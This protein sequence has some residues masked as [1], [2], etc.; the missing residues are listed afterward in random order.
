[1]AAQIEHQGA[2]VG[3]FLRPESVIEGGSYEPDAEERA[4][5]TQVL[6][7]VVESWPT[8]SLGVDETTAVDIPS[9]ASVSI[10]T[11]PWKPVQEEEVIHGRFV[12]QS[13]RAV[14]DV[15]PAPAPARRTTPT[16][17]DTPA[18]A[19]VPTLRSPQ[20]LPK[21]KAT[22]SLPPV[23]DGLTP[24]RSS[25]VVRRAPHLPDWPARPS[26]AQSYRKENLDVF[27]EKQT[28]AEQRQAPIQRPLQTTALKDQVL[29]SP[30]LANLEF[31]AEHVPTTLNL[32]A[33]E[34]SEPLS[35]SLRPVETAEKPSREAS[36]KPQSSMNMDDVYRRWSTF[37]E[38]DGMDATALYNEHGEALERYKGGKE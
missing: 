30:D 16:M 7:D 31:P 33:A 19:A 20:R 24:R 29:S 13:P 11:T 32:P 22:P 25:A 35:S 36:S 1:M 28:R 4:E 18:P 37:D 17:P 3:A 26:N 15:Q 23:G 21:R 9:G 14:E 34:G 12:S 5:A 8:S 27:A 2:K 6:A 38:P 10:G